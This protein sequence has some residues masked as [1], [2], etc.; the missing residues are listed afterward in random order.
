M[1]TGYQADIGR[2]SISRDL[3]TGELVPGPV[4]S[5]EIRI[6]HDNREPEFW[7]TRNQIQFEAYRNILERFLNERIAVM[8]GDGVQIGWVTP[9]I[10]VH[11]SEQLDRFHA[12]NRSA[13]LAIAEAEDRRI[14]EALACV[15][16][17]KPYKADHTVRF[18]VE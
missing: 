3:E 12:L 16:E 14:F 1:I 15:C 7:S 6:D 8:R 5:Y 10:E 18:K 9:L 11:L 2:E 13:Q 4:T 17:E